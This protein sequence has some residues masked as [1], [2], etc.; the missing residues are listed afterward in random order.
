M[1]PCRQTAAGTNNATNRPEN[2]FYMQHGYVPDLVSWTL[3]NAY[4]D[5]CVGNF[6][7][8]LGKTD[9]ARLFSGRAAN[10][11]KI[12]DP[13]VQSMRARN[14]NGDWIPWQGKTT[15]G[16]GCTESNL[17]D[18]AWASVTAARKAGR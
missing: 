2:E 11:K 12:Y 3:D 1:L 9:D 17:T 5:W 6:A 10:Y 8:S 15:F 4:Y 13:Q 18:C 7:A 16:Q 14:A